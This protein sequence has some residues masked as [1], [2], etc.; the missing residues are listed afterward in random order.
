MVFEAVDEDYIEYPKKCVK[1]GND[2]LLVE[3]RMTYCMNKNIVDG[4]VEDEDTHDETHYLLLQVH[5]GCDVRGGYTEPRVF[6]IIDFFSFLNAQND[7]FAHCDCDKDGQ[8]SSC[9]QGY[10][11][12]GDG[13]GHDKL[14]KKWKPVPK[15]DPVKMVCSKCKGEVQFMPSL[16]F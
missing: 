2:E 15:K 3:G 13:R 14:P 10:D 9:N 16:E 12:Q 7:L 1:C 6:R 5:G 4:V 11:W 8:Y